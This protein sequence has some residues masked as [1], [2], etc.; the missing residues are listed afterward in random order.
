MFGRVYLTRRVFKGAAACAA[1]VFMSIGVEIEAPASVLA[2]CA[3]PDS[4]T[5]SSVGN[6]ELTY[7]LLDDA[8]SKISLTASL[9]LTNPGLG[10]ATS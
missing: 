2:S 1:M 6:V 8:L 9:L 5:S 7:R 10:V 4:L 3:A